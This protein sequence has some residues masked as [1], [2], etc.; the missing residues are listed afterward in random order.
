VRLD[1]TARQVATAPRINRSGLYRL[2]GNAWRNRVYGYYG[3][4]YGGTA[5]GSPPCKGA[6]YGAAGQPAG[7]YGGNCAYPGSPANS[8]NVS[9]GVNNGGNNG[10]QARNPSTGSIGKQGIASGN[11]AGNGTL[12]VTRNGIQS[13]L[14]KASAVS[15]RGLRNAN[16]YAKSG[17]LIGSIDH[18]MIDV[19]NGRIAFV[20]V[21]RGGFLGLN[22]TWYAIP[23]EALNWS[24]YGNGFRLGVNQQQLRGLP[25]IPAI[26]GNLET[27]VPRGQLTRLYQHFDVQPYWQARNDRNANGNQNGG[28]NSATQSK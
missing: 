21:K 14:S 17:D 24:A 16:V 10:N 6:A 18:V 8:G 12:A 2:T 4:R 26:N 5:L 11:A 1:V 27:T 7:Q 23:L 9:N 28:A 3:Y 19:D 25:T 20:L 15:P 13:L 22:P